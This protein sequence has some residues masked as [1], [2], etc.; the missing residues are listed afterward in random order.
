MRG[1]LD[2][3]PAK[4]SQLAMESQLLHQQPKAQ[5]EKAFHGLVVVYTARRFYK[6]KFHQFYVISRISIVKKIK[7]NKIAEHKRSYFLWFC[8][9]YLGLT[10]TMVSLSSIPHARLLAK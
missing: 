7:E 5:L 10:Y 4:T 3:D 1:K 9:D 6:G 2:M 8:R